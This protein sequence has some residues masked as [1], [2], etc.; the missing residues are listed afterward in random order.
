MKSLNIRKNCKCYFYLHYLTSLQK[1]TSWHMTCNVWREASR[2]LILTF[3]SFDTIHP[4]HAFDN[5]ARDGD[6]LVALRQVTPRA[7]R[8][9]RR[10]VGGTTLHKKSVHVFRGLRATIKPEPESEFVTG[11]SIDDQVLFHGADRSGWCRETILEIKSRISGLI[12]GSN[13][14]FFLFDW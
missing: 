4:C 13:L 5:L 2:K 3:Q 10:T 14:Y 6:D 1:M 12:I 8:P 7:L 11:K 9:R